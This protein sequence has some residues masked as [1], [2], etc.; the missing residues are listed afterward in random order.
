MNGE[1]RRPVEGF[2]CSSEIGGDGEV[3]DQSR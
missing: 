1:E 3:N 2:S